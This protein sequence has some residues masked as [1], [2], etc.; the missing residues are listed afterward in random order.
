MSQVVEDG[1]MPP[2]EAARVKRLERGV[3]LTLAAVQFTSIVDFMVVMPLGP[4]LMR[5]LEINPD[6]FGLIVSSYTFSAG[7]AGLFASALIDRFDRKRAFLALYTGFLVGTL[8]CGL[9]GSFG[10]LLAARI[11]T[12]AFGGVLGGMALAIIA[13]VFPPHRHGSATAALMSAFAVASVAGVPFG[14]SVGIEYGW[15]APFLLL[16]ALGTIVLAAGAWILPPLRGH[17]NPAKPAAHPLEALWSTFAHPNHIR[18]FTLIVTL[19]FGSFAVVPYI[20]PYLVANV[21]VL[22]KRLPLVYILGG[23]LT[24][25]VAPLIGKLADRYG[26]LPVYR[27]VAPVAAVLMILV[28]NMP[29]VHLA[30]AVVVV[31]VLMVSN[32]GRMVAA[33]AMVMASVEPKKRGSFMSANSSVQHLASGLGAF[34]GGQIIVK[35]PDGSLANFAWVGLLGVI[36][37]LL[38]LILAGRLRA[39]GAESPIPAGL[40][41][42]AAAEALGEPGDPLPAAETV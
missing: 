13:D 36:A 35:N 16:A 29:K 18:A 30:V 27:C 23:A 10:T 15:P 40:A 7:I 25:V 38:S 41:I 9:A 32:A 8:L 20:S 14:L 1:S 42:G 4:Q 28:T 26:K 19:M 12:G 33:M 3:V 6:K 22:E 2:E 11:V 5:T 31:A 37:T 34:V 17:L 21:G 39:V 24:L